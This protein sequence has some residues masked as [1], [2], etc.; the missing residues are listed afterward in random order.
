MASLPYSDAF[1]PANSFF[2]RCVTCPNTAP[3]CPSCKSDEI[4]SQTLG[5]CETCP[6]ASC[7]KA[8]TSGSL[9]G[10][11][12]KSSGPNIG[13]IVGGVIGGVALITL[14]VFCIWKYWLKGRRHE[15]E[16]EE[17]EDDEEME[18]SNASVFTR[19]ARSRASTH[20]VA[21]LAS[22]VLTRAS[23]I[24]QIA[25]IPGVTNRSGNTGPDLLVPPVPPIPAQTPP[26]LHSR[27]ADDQLLFM[28]GDLRDSTYSDVSSVSGER[29]PGSI[30]PSLARTSM[31][32]T[33][34]MD[35]AV[36][37]PMPAT[38]IIGGKAAIVSVGSKGSTP[39]STPPVP[40]VDFAK[41]GGK[42]VKPVIIKMPSS[43]D[44][45]GSAT[46]SLKTMK[47]VA[48]NIIRK[49]KKAPSDVA[50]VDSSALESRDSK[51]M[52]KSS[53]APSEMS[54]ET[55]RRARQSG[56]THRS[57]RHTTYSDLSDDD[58]EHER[59]RQSL[60]D[61]RNESP[62]TDAAE[63]KTPTT[64]SVPGGSPL[65]ISTPSSSK[66]AAERGKSPFEDPESPTK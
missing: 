26:T 65:K 36:V 51:R 34:F 53:L 64:P 4:C 19:E 23:N 20:T 30:A 17:W 22:T 39:G 10:T 61:R 5:D 24:I 58:D 60:M 32:S 62:F 57:S 16:I 11:S 44:G 63:I 56:L 12:S 31:A 59:S 27:F 50:S 8:A 18:K 41:H 33:I 14:I 9:V 1:S 2:K 55:H 29:R 46:S 54:V 42:A 15:V 25:Y 7:V 52:T 37:N 47:P 13:A 45:S 21:S 35:S 49:D 28:P 43:T 48:L 66:E 40:S 3:T 38:Q 6:T